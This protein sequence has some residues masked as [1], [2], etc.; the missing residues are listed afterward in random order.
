[1]KTKKTKMLPKTAREIYNGGVYQQMV[2]CGKK[3]CKCARGEKHVAYYFFT[4]RNGKLTKTYI[5]KAQLE[6][7]TQLVAE[8]KNRKKEYCVERMTDAQLIRNM[9]RLA[10]ERDLFIKATKGIYEGE[11]EL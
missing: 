7:F 5:H 10:R 9:N 3:N 6:A 8:S 1:M 4:R 11:F 2:K